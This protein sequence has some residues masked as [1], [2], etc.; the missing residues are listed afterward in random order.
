MNIC[1]YSPQISPGNDAITPPSSSGPVVVLQDTVIFTYPFVTP[2]LTVELRAPEFNNKDSV[3]ITR[4]IRD[5]RG[6]EI[7]VYKESFWPTIRRLSFVIE[8]LSEVEADGLQELIKASIGKE[9][10][11]LD[12]EGRQWKGIIL[13]PEEAIT[14]EGVNCEYTAKIDFEGALQ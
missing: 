7:K 3:L 13:N 5:T 2:T 12:Y 14:E 11:Y 1:T 6:G 8:S 4:I 9:I 10:G